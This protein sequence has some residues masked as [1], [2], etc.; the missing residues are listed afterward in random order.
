MK[1]R[2]SLSQTACDA[3]YFDTLASPIGELRLVAD[4]HGL[5][6]VCFEHDRHPQACDAGGMRDPARLQ[7]ARRQLEEYFAGTR[8]TFDLELHVVGTS[9]QLQVWKALRGIPYGETLSYA[10]LA[11]RIGQPS[12]CRAVGAANG[13]NPLPIIVPCHRVIGSNGTLV[14]FGG[15]LDVKQAL[16]ALERANAPTTH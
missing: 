15:G 5:R 8:R 13:R 2:A 3:L 6:R 14:G 1:H 7:R 11:E 4:V 12:A 16:L 9:F 10:G